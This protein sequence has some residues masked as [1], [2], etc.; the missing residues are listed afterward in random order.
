MQIGYVFFLKPPGVKHDHLIIDTLGLWLIFFILWWFFFVAPRTKK[1]MEPILS[2][3][4]FLQGKSTLI[5]RTNQN[6]T[7]EN[8]YITLHSQRSHA[9][10]RICNFS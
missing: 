2:T 1:L 9:L 10:L 3:Y 6:T 4:M 5:I 7:K 8:C